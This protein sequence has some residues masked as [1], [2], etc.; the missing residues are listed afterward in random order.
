MKIW[1][2]AGSSCFDCALTDT[3]PKNIEGAEPTSVARYAVK[4][5]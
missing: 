2:V 4:S 3:A 5:F 1:R